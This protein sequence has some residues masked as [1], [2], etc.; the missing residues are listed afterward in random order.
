MAEASARARAKGTIAAAISDGLVHLHKEYYG[1]GPTKAKTYLV[2]DTAICMLRGGFTVVERTL[3]QDGKAEAV[4]DVR[5]VFQ[6]SMQERFTE[7]VQDATGRNVVA[8]M[9]QIHSD[10][11]IAVEIFVLEAG[12][13][14][15][16]DEHELD[17]D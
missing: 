3:I 1:K 2:N 14:P 12:D 17:L 10:P 6:S 13:E 7:V 15:L 9:S 8:Y 5:R 11:D 16:L 4:H